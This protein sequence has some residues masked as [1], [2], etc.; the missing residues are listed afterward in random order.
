MPQVGSLEEE[1]VH[2]DHLW[3]V[4]EV[5][6]GGEQGHILAVVWVGC[7]SIG[8]DLVDEGCPHGPD[9]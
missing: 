2:H 9:G 8:R 4:E 1:E 5:G 3:Q 6:I 7:M